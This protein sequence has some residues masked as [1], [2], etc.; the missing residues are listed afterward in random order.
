MVLTGL[1][2]ERDYQPD[3]F[4]II[5]TDRRRP[6]GFLSEYIIDGFLICKEDVAVKAFLACGKVIG[7]ESLITGTAVYGK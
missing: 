3:L 5:I 7:A 2:V 1:H 4:F 6:G